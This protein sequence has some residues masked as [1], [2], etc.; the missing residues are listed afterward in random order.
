MASNPRDP[1]ERQV[2]LS[3]V[4]IGII[5]A[6]EIELA[7]CLEVFDP[8][9][10]SEEIVAQ[11]TS[12]LFK[13]RVCRIP[14]TS[15][16]NVA[17]AITLLMDMGNNAAAIGA[18]ILLQHCQN[19]R[20]IIM[21]G[22]A[23]AVP[24]PGV[25]D[26]HVRLGDIVISD[27]NGVIQYDRGKQHARPNPPTS[28]GDSVDD[29]PFAGF[30]ERAVRCSPCPVL[31]HI[32]REII[33]QECRLG[34]KEVRRWEAKIKQVV[35]R[36]SNVK[37]WKRP[38]SSKDV[39]DDS[40]DGSHPTRH[41][42]DSA[43]RK[44]GDVRCPRVFRGPIASANIVLADPSMRDALRER[45]RVKAVEMEGSGIADA[46]WIGSGVGYL[47]VRGACDYC[48]SQKNKDWHPYAALIAAAFVHTLI[49][50]C[51]TS[52]PDSTDGRVPPTDSQ[53]P[54][55]PLRDT[56]KSHDSAKLQQLAESSVPLPVP[57]TSPT[58]TKPLNLPAS[59]ADF[60]ADDVVAKGSA[61]Q[62]DLSPNLAAF[63]G[64]SPLDPGLL[65]KIRELTSQIE[66]LLGEYELGDVAVL[67]ES[68]ETALCGAPREGFVVREGWIL[69]A[70]V[71]FKL[72]A[73]AKR[74]G[75][76]FDLKRYRAFLQEAENVVG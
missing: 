16:G 21:C 32:V 64:K 18:N 63:P 6:L 20:H 22:I 39:L 8:D 68:L 60:G 72:I 9:D 40:N 42:R 5:A 51:P 47:I 12:G 52:G 13:C 56:Q 66:R 74:S 53:P 41:P 38:S 57:A 67:A 25:P 61:K 44:L 34:P 33:A 3:D 28:N 19:V 30:E 24:C 46:A 1:P 23:G 17:V 36:A 7:A 4:T 29:G 48:N 62:I 73:D 49:E 26:D 65:G 45:H 27:R 55:L 75:T 76:P 59:P 31:T 69:L 54:E 35:E 70:K 14:T 2:A 10:T 43:R 50:D 71:E 15:G 37:K 58:V 11:S